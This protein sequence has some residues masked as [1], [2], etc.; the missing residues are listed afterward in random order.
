M[1]NEH[2]TYPSIRRALRG[3]DHVANF[4]CGVK[5]T[6]WQM[7][8][9][10]GAALVLLVVGV[11]KFV[12]G[13]IVPF[14]VGVKRT[15]GPYLGPYFDRFAGWL[16]DD[17]P[18]MFYHFTDWL[19]NSAIPRFGAWLEQR[20]LAFGGWVD[21]LIYK[22]ADHPV[23]Q[24]LETIFTVIAMIISVPLLILIIAGE[25]INTRTGLFTG[26]ASLAI[27][28]VETIIDFI[29]GGAS[30][31]ISCT[32]DGARR[33]ARG[34]KEKA[35]EMEE[36]PG[37]RRIYGYCPVSF[38]IRPKWFDSLVGDYIDDDDDESEPVV[39]TDGGVSRD[40]N[41]SGVTYTVNF[42]HNSSGNIRQKY[43]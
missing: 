8:Y 35:N 15:L 12:D 34:V 26:L 7:I 6:A 20:I 5:W 17:E 30:Q 13:Y 10:L 4:R 32:S 31:S 27:F 42:Y 11:V 39:V 33:F 9:G 21:S 3:N 28:T 24:A 41:S 1:S 18:G 23:G 29:K 40:T 2:D 25:E 14:G 38:D 19:V 37:T 36:R 16:F 43:N 22:F